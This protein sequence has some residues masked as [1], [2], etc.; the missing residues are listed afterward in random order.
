MN[1][2]RVFVKI[3][4]SSISTDPR[5]FE[6]SSGGNFNGKHGWYQCRIDTIHCCI[7]CFHRSMH[8]TI[9]LKF[10]H[11]AHACTQTTYVLSFPT[12]VPHCVSWESSSKQW[13]TFSTKHRKDGFF[14]R[15][16][17]VIYYLKH[18]PKITQNIIEIHYKS[19]M[20]ES[21]KS[22]KI[23]WIQNMVSVSYFRADYHNL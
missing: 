14:L 21:A 22:E 19:L 8:L 6:W 12:P 15:K 20:Q 4:D 10:L 11:I 9:N 3:A 23:W 2:R 16:L 5:K 1:T 17:F 18:V 13:M 7:C